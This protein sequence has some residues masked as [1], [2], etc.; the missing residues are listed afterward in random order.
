MGYQWKSTATVVRVQET[1]RTR[2]LVQRLTQ[3]MDETKACL[4]HTLTYTPRSA[5]YR[6]YRRGKNRCPRC[7]LKLG[8]P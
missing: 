8:T 6:P 2:R 3:H 5:P 4:L 1:P 7:G